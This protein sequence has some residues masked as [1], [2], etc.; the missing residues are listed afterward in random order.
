MQVQLAGGKIRGNRD[1]EARHLIAH[2]GERFGRATAPAKVA[3][4]RTILAIQSSGPEREK[5]YD[6]DM[7]LYLCEMA[8]KPEVQAEISA[9]IALMKK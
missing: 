5:A 1:E 4:R 8:G 9:N 7:A 6:S 3:L 2:A